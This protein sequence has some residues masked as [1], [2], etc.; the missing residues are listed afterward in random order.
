MPSRG[1]FPCYAVVMT[2]TDLPERYGRW[3]VVSKS[4]PKSPSGVKWMFG[5]TAALNERSFATMSSAVDR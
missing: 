2:D 5:A 4:G 3:T 1:G